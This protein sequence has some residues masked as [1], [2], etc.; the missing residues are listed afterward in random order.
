MEI[1][2][3]QSRRGRKKVGVKPKFQGSVSRGHESPHQIS[4]SSAHDA[5]LASPKAAKKVG[6]KS[7][8]SLARQGSRP[9]HSP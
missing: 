2:V 1:S 3:H 5:T 7:R 6:V 8:N 9:G 4:Q